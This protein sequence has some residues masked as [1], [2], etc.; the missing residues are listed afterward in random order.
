M[1]YRRLGASGLEV[2]PLCLGTMTFGDR[3][4]AAEAQRIV[5]AAFGPASAHRHRRRLRQD[6]TEQMV[7]AAIHAGGSAGFSPP[8]QQRAD[9]KE[10]RRRASAALDPAAYDDSLARL[11]TDYIDVY[12]HRDDSDRRSPGDRRDRPHSQQRIPYFG[13]SGTA[14]GASRVVAGMGAGRAAQ[15]SAAVVQPAEPDA[16][17]EILRP[18][19]L[20]ARRRAVLADRARRADRQVSARRRAEFARRA[21][22]RG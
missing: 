5:D 7:G 22:H 3:T 19:V 13:V 17:V 6:V 11:A 21:A 18:A 20:R 10:A 2:S 12:L 15:S 1:Q 16:R 14:A 9:R 4:D 8:G